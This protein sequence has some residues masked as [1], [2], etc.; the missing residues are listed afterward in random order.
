M[1]NRPGASRGEV[2]Q[3]YA[4]ESAVEAHCR[5]VAALALE[6][7]HR[8]Q[9]PE[10]AR[11]TIE[12]VALLHHYPLTFLDAEALARLMTDMCGANW[13]GSID[14]DAISRVRPATQAALRALHSP[15]PA[16]KDRASIIAEIVEM[17]N[18]FDEQV[19]YLPY[20]YKTTDQI[21]DGLRIISRDDLFLPEIILSL[22][23]L[24][25]VGKEQVLRNVDGLPVFPSMAL[26]AIEPGP[27]EGA[28]SAQ[29]LQL[30]SSDP[31]LADSLLQVANS[32]LH[33][34]GKRILTARQAIAF[35]GIKAARKVLT[36]AAIRPVF[37]AAKAVEMWKHS[38]LVAQM[39][40]RLAVVSAR[41]DPKEA[42]LAGLVHDVGRLAFETLTGEVAI[43]YERM[44]ARK[45]EPIFVEKVLCGSDHAEV[46]TDLLRRWS[47]P[48]RLIA[49]VR[50]HHQPEQTDSGLASLLYL[51]EYWSG[52]EEDLSST[53][54]LQL[55]M[56]RTGI[57]IDVMRSTGLPNGLLDSLAFRRLTLP[58]VPD[59]K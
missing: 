28:A 46:V 45:C 57:S 16:A 43:I 49:A 41:A 2:A 48:E 35:I 58:S 13:L 56:D 27:D 4:S 59:S 37:A 15:A 18:L 54:R 19:E 24:P 29:L 10:S 23:S 47:F 3:T 21:L 50:H 5:R 44:I 51:A 32:E 17:A 20:D 22:T 33:R 6:I 14:M 52:S 55:A 38:L 26:R 8:L 12:Q 31:A 40:E 36:A 11:Q 39:A 34:P 9:L 30:A 1:L 42:F 25:R 7:A 53:M